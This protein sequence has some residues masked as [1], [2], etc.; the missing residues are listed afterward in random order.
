MG[1]SPPSHWVTS[2]VAEKP[3]SRVSVT[4]A[5]VSLEGSDDSGDALLSASSLGNL[6]TAEVVFSS[7]CVQL[8]G[9]SP[10]GGQ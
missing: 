9:T 1:L 8:K 7:L 5:D 6:Y 3:D 4:S 10:L 2:S